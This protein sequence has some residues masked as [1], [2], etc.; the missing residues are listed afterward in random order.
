MKTRHRNSGFTLVELMVTLAVAAIVVAI[1]VPNF[2]NAVNNNR[3]YTNSND[4]LAVLALARSEAVKQRAAVTLCVS[5][6]GSSCNVSTNNWEQGWLVFTDANA[7]GSLDAGTDTILRIGNGLGST[8]TMTV[9]GSA[10]TWVQ[11]RSRGEI[12]TGVTFVLCDQR[13]VYDARGLS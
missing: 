5:S 13:G 4:F 3:L 12:N 9:V 11:F 6:N 8:V 10:T 1:V 2:E 7:N